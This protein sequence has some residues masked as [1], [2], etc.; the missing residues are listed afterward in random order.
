MSTH[1]PGFQS[2]FRF[3]HP[4]VLVKLVTSSIRVNLCSGN[5]TVFDDASLLSI[6]FKDTTFIQL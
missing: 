6:L 4:F 5:I 2:F 3:L 1:M